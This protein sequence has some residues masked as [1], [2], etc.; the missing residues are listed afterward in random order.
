MNDKKKD[1][2]LPQNHDVSNK[3]ILACQLCGKK[4][5]H[6]TEGSDELFQCLACGFSTSHKFQGKKKGNEDF[7]KLDD[8]IK[9]WAVENDGYIWIPSV[10]NLVVGLYYPIDVKNKLMWALAPLV[11][12]QKEEQKNYPV[13]GQK[14]KFYT[15]RYDMDNQMVFDDFGEGLKTL[16]N[17][18]E[19]Q[20]KQ[21]E[22]NQPKVNIK[23]QD[24]P[25]K[26]K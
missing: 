10:M 13:P 1:F 23:V 26:S 14:D 18:L 17:T 24:A 4:E 8:D 5:L 6:V 7:E 11:P 25:E 9:K 2:I 12:I 20:R 15:R 16:N 21:F 22:M 3:V 19:Q